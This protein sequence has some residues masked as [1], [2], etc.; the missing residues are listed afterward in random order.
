[1][2]TQ[3]QKQPK[4]K[5]WIA[6]LLKRFGKNSESN[7]TLDEWQKLESKKQLN[8]TKEEFNYLELH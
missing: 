3:N 7:F 6:S 5:K 2:K 4:K 1:M 8:S